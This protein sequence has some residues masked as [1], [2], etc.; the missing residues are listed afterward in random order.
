MKFSGSSKTLESGLMKERGEFDVED[1]RVRSGIGESGSGGGRVVLGFVPDRFRT[2]D[3]GSE[4]S[5]EVTMDGVSC[6]VRS[7]AAEKEG[8]SRLR[9]VVDPL[10]GRDVSEVMSS[11][12]AEGPAEEKF[13]PFCDFVSV[14]EVP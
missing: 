1:D 13:D 2:S 8:R 9:G 5:D 4:S 6:V 11:P 7:C 10:I 3:C 12:F 14:E